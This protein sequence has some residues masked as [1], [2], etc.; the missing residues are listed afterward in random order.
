MKVKVQSFQQIAFWSWD[1]KDDEVCGICR[2]HFEACCPECKIP[3]DD[4]PLSNFHR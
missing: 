4:C 2:N 1:V 3:G